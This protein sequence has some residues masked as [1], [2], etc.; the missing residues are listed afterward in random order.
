MKFIQENSPKTKIYV[1]SVLPVNEDIPNRLGHADNED[2]IRLNTE[3]KKLCLHYGIK[4][5]DLFPLFKN[6]KNK[7]KE[8]FT[9]DGLHPNGKGYLVWKSAIE[10]YLSD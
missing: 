6:E 1:Q 8:Q 7:L 9:F 5:I 4:F 10:K 2:V 3:L